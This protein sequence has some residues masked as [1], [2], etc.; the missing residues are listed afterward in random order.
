MTT[1]EVRDKLKVDDYG[2]IVI[3]NKLKYRI[4]CTGTIVF[5]SKKGTI[6]FYDNEKKEYFVAPE[7]IVSFERKEMLPLPKEYNNREVSFDGGRF[8]YT[9]T[10][11]EVDLK[12]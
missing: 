5:I 9:K 8:V 7:N 12:R 2:E 11:R 4:T 1:Q 6:V 3:I 10:G